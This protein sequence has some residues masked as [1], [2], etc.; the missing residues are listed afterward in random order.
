MPRFIVPMCLTFF[1]HKRAPAMLTSQLDSK[2]DRCLVTSAHSCFK[3]SILWLIIPIIEQHVYMELF[4]YVSGNWVGIFAGKQTYLDNGISPIPLSTQQQPMPVV[5]GAGGLSSH[6][7]DFVFKLL[8]TIA[9]IVVS[10][11]PSYVLQHISNYLEWTFC[12]LCYFLAE[13]CAINC[14]HRKRR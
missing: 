8:A 10:S 13:T 6:F 5:Q 4:R 12:S 14:R 7:T 3:R 1:S 9:S 2:R 11:Q